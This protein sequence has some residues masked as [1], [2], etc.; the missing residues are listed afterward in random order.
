M[1]LTVQTFLRTALSN[2]WFTNHPLDVM[3]LRIAICI[4][5]IISACFLA[6]ISKRFTEYI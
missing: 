1:V 3:P 4:L 5:K 2:V 6:G